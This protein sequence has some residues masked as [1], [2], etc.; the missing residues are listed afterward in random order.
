MEH[1]QGVSIARCY[2]FFQVDLS[3]E[4]EVPNWCE[5]SEES[6]EEADEEERNSLR[7]SVYSQEWSAELKAAVENDSEESS[8]KEI[9]KLKTQ[10]PAEHLKFVQKHH[11]ISILVLERLK[12]HLPIGV[13]LHGIQ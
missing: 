4:Y 13:P 9:V 6:A 7:D 12:G 11:L 2:G 3:E 5:I 8:P 10:D 1:L